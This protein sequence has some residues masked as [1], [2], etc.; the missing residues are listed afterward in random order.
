MNMRR[1]FRVATAA[2]LLSALPVAA[3]RDLN[4][5]NQ[6]QPTADDLTGSP[7]RATLGR[8]AVGIQIEAFADLA[9]EIQQFGIYGRE[10]L[11]LLG[12]DPRETG[13][14]LRG[15]QDPGGRAGGSWQGKY[16][17][18]RTIHTY[19]TAL[20]N[21]TVVTD[22]ERR[23][24][25]GFAKTL[26]AWHLHRLAVR[27]GASGLP[28]DTDRPIDAEPAPL[29]SAADA[30]AAASALLD[31]A[32]AD[33]QAGGST[34]P[35][36]FAPGYTGF[37]TPAT[38]AQFNRALATK[39]LVHRATFAACAACW[40]QAATALGQSFV[41]DAGL[42]GSLATGVYYGYTGTANELNNPVTETLANDRYWA[43]QSIVAG[44]QLRPNGQPD[45]RLT[46]KTAPAG[47]TRTFNDVTATHKPVLYNNPANPAEANN[48]AD[49]PWIT[50]EE[51]LLLRAEIRWNTANRAGA[52][53][54]I[55]LIRQHAGGLAPS[56]L[57]AASSDAAF[58]TELLYN[59][60]YSL[61]FTQ[62]VRWVDAR[63]YGRLNTLPLDRTGD[64]VH[65]H[66]LIPSAE[67]D[68]RG[69]EPPCAVQ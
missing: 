38:F 7:S 47:R 25:Q 27:S 29:V 53:S 58:V 64:V 63:R 43:H 34:F 9:G 30:M 24:S 32:L 46:T 28:I 68:A 66:M 4:V 57:T 42:P 62:G 59:R 5:P 52:V 40:A 12:N 39:V 3:C 19:L 49:I 61:L 15:P 56:G 11:N 54:D 20:G 55:D 8:A 22:E 50:N 6:N 35:F 45:L 10:L 41:T 36:A 23:A 21:T 67:C 1:Q 18:I 17:A 26:K 31:E 51:L 33:L 16:S 13:E 2:A 60:L 44:A 69:L 37:T 65:P 48:G 14:E